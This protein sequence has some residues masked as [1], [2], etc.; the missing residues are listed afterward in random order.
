[1]DPITRAMLLREAQS[2]TRMSL[3]DLSDLVRRKGECPIHDNQGEPVIAQRNYAVAPG[4]YVTEW[5]EENDTTLTELAFDLGVAESYATELISGKIP[6]SPSIAI[7]LEHLTGIPVRSWNR[8]DT[9]YW[10]DKERIARETSVKDDRAARRDQ[11]LGEIVEEDQALLDRLAPDDAKRVREGIAAAKDG[12]F[13]GVEFD[14]E[15]P[16][17]NRLADER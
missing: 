1:M 10:Q 6:V 8:L 7:Q 5:L 2:T 3:P 17:V 11:L 4:E 14:H 16:L 9:M 15:E 13:K 12:T